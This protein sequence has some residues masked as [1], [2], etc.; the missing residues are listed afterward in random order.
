MEIDQ[1]PDKKFRQGFTRAPVAAGAAGRGRARTISRVP[2]S[3]AP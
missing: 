2:C 3:L 1:R